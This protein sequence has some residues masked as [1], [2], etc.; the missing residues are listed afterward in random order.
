VSEKYGSPQR[1][2]PQ[3]YQ[4]G[5]PERRLAGETTLSQA[6]TQ[7][8]RVHFNFDTLYE[9]KV[10]ANPLVK[11]RYCFNVGDWFKVNHPTGPK[12]TG[13]GPDD[14]NR[15]QV[16]LDI[17]AENKWCLC[18]AEDLITP[19]WRDFVIEATR[20]H[21]EDIAKYL[22]VKPV[23]GNLMFTK[24]EGSYPAM[25]A[26]TKQQGSYC[27]ADCVKGSHV[28]VPDTLCEV[29]VASDVV[30]SVVGP[31][32]IPGIGGTGGSCSADQNGRPV[33]LVFSWYARSYDFSRDRA[34]LLESTRGLIIHELFHGLGFGSGGWVNVFGADGGRRKI[35]E[36][37][38]VTDADGSEDVVYFFVKGTRTYEAAKRYFGCSDEDQW[39]GL[40][41]MSWPPHGR[42]SHHE[43]RVL[44]DDVMSYGDGDAVSAITLASFEDMG[45]YVADYRNADCIH[46]GQGRGCPFISSRCEE[47]PS[48]Q[49][50][51]GLASSQCD[52]TWTAAK[53]TDQALQ[54]CVA[55]C[56]GS[57][58]IENGKSLCDVEC[59]TGE[60]SELER[61]GFASCQEAPPGEI[62][63]AGPEKW[64]DDLMASAVNLQHCQ[65]DFTGDPCMQALLQL[66]WVV[67]VPLNICFWGLCCKGI[68]CPAGQQEKS[69][70][71]FYILTGFVF[72][73]G[74]LAAAGAG[75]ILAN[76]EVI[77]GYMSVNAV[78][79]MCGAGA[80]L[81]IFCLIGMYAVRRGYRCVMI[82]YLIIGLILLVIFI[83]AAGLSAKY[84]QDVDGLSRSSIA[85]AGE[86]G[87]TWDEKG[88]EKDVYAQM[89][90]FACR[91][92]QTCCEPTE[93]F[94]LREA[95]G[96]GRQCKAQ[97]EGKAE[98]AAFILADPSHPKF[99]PLLSGVT[100]HF[101]S[102]EGVCKLVELASGGGFT[103]AQCQQDYCQS[104]LEGY[105]NFIAVT[106][107][108]YRS[109]MLAAGIIAACVVIFIIVQLWNLYYI[110]RQFHKSPVVPV[111]KD[112]ARHVPQRAED[113]QNKTSKCRFAE[114]FKEA[115]LKLAAVIYCWRLVVAA[116]LRGAKPCWLRPQEFLQGFGWAVQRPQGFT[117]VLLSR[118]F[119]HS[120]VGLLSSVVLIIPTLTGPVVGFL[121]DWTPL[122]KRHLLFAG[123]VT[124][125][126]IFQF[127]AMPALS[128]SHDAAYWWVFACLSLQAACGHGAIFT[129]I[130][131]RMV[132]K[133]AYGKVRLWGGV[134]FAT[135]SFLTGILVKELGYEVIFVESMLVGV[136]SAGCAMMLKGME[137]RAVGKRPDKD[138]SPSLREVLAFLTCPHVAILL[139][140]VIALS[141]GEGVMQTYTYIRLEHLPN[142]TSTIMGLSAIFMIIS[143]VPFFYYANPIFQ[144]F[145]I[146]PILCL[147]LWCMALRQEWIACL[148]D[149]LW[150]LPGELLHG[151]T[152]SIANAAVTLSVHD[153]TPG[154]L[155][156]T[157]QSVVG[158]FC[159][160]FGQSSAS[161]FGGLVVCPHHLEEVPPEVLAL[162]VSR[163]VTQPKVL[164]CTYTGRALRLQLSELII[165]LPFMPKAR[166]FRAYHWSVGAKDRR[167]DCDRIILELCCEWFGSVN[168]FER[169]VRSQIS[170]LIS[171]W[172]TGL[173][174]LIHFA[175]WLAYLLRAPRQTCYGELFANILV[176]VAAAVFYG[177]MQGLYVRLY[178]MVSHLNP[179]TKSS[180]FDGVDFVIYDTMAVANFVHAAILGLAILVVYG[181]G[182][183]VQRLSSLGTAQAKSLERR[184]LV[185]HSVHSSRKR[186]LMADLEVLD[187][188]PKPQPD[189]PE[190]ATNAEP[191]FQ[192]PPQVLALMVSRDVTQPEVLR[193][194]Y[195]GRAL[196]WG[197]QALR[198]KVEAQ[199]AH[200]LSWPCERIAQFWSHSW[201][202]SLWAKVLT[203]LLVQ[204]GTAAVCCG[205]L[206]CIVHGFLWRELAPDLRG[207]DDPL[208]TVFSMACGILVAA[209]TLL[210]WSSGKTVFV[211]QLCIHQKDAQLKL[212]GVLSMGGFLKASESCLVCWDDS[213]S[214]RL[215]CLFELAAFLT[216]REDL[217]L[218]VRPTALGPAVLLLSGAVWGTLLLT[219]LEA[220]VI[221]AY[222]SAAVYAEGMMQVEAL[223]ARSLV[224]CLLGVTAGSYSARSFRAYHW[225]VECMERRLLGFELKEAK[226]SCCSLD[227]KNATGA[228]IPCDRI[229]L[230]LCICEWFGSVNSFERNVRSQVLPSLKGQL[231]PFALPYSWMLGAC[232]PV[233]WGMLPRLILFH[234]DLSLPDVLSNFHRQ[235]SWLISWWLAGLPLLIHFAMWLAYLLRAPRQ[236]C[237]GELFTNMLVCVAAAVFY[238]LMQGLYVLLYV[239][240]SHLNPETK[241]G[242]WDSVEFVIYDT[243]AVA[244]V[245]HAA[246]LGL[247]ILV[248]YGCRCRSAKALIFG[249]RPGEAEKG[250]SEWDSAPVRY[251]SDACASRGSQTSLAA[252][253]RRVQLSLDAAGAAHTAIEPALLKSRADGAAASDPSVL[254]AAEDLAKGAVLFEERSSLCTCGHPGVKLCTVCGQARLCGSCA[255]RM[256]LLAL[257]GP[258]LKITQGQVLRRWEEG[259]LPAESLAAV[260]A[261]PTEAVRS[262]QAVQKVAHFCSA[263]RWSDRRAEEILAAVIRG[264]IE[265]A[266]NASPVGIGYYPKF[267]RLRAANAHA[268]AVLKEAVPAGEP[269]RVG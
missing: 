135:G 247:A 203:L 210:L 171:W 75:A 178:V 28:L 261:V 173:P 86:S 244:N 184:I 137:E 195:A 15:A 158:S 129:E 31:S 16:G 115:V 143:E 96:A 241:T 263:V 89:E 256:C 253:S 200:R 123:L 49:T 103:L 13:A 64:A 63:S 46:W 80:A 53:A 197:G 259:H 167:P 48:L 18:T 101:S 267:A 97:H 180:N 260:A 153:I 91:T 156:T 240:V 225:C 268:E 133:E 152:F 81:A 174:L 150:V 76:Q 25:W 11:D 230:E 85:Q 254:V 209:L 236:T 29:G 82:S 68:L 185:A 51:T 252:T 39:Q 194:T 117:V 7:R 106:V 37:K 59:F 193:C 239:M 95:N 226:C 14:C 50:V 113:P 104:G 140:L 27:D 127:A 234:A 217:K 114:L 237:Y 12:P 92:Y 249:H 3:R 1:Q 164:R 54:K 55:G 26:T 186:E 134:G 136:A 90:S 201:H 41:L 6:N 24:S 175:M 32:P 228:R 132:G 128:W 119:S 111:G 130:V 229:I 172:L 213:Y 204:N 44:R 73:C 57:S 70:K 250:I 188:Y 131:L 60:S 93:L 105:E 124:M 67:L 187:E 78:Y 207:A 154:H 182:V 216:S 176:C 102:A 205:T 23:Q 159:S 125:R 142:G 52:R 79:V 17:M 208:I 220:A 248:V 218:V 199:K 9:D 255:C 222:Q 227:H 40:P 231:G 33:H 179:E 166:S 148:W 62:S 155:E 212:E 42:D 144:R 4:R 202:G 224:V 71:I 169:N 251:C 109:N 145:G 192:V 232:A 65:D 190:S 165:A 21:G 235:F 10:N 163:D 99:C 258:E 221:G 257:I 8:I 211:D 74:I 88:M 45:H 138:R 56:S 149:A 77:E 122:E 206:A 38:K 238:G 215:W 139:F 121:G 5:T 219:E 83:V 2:S 69:K 47:R 34:T 112:K 160:G 242:N 72:L 243:L 181:C 108:I 170:W 20:L 168:S 107:S 126:W 87:G 19:A 177:F 183:E 66:S 98:D 214:E 118:R 189:D 233:M 151:I 265:H 223:A 110:I 141:F 262:A 162:M 196:S 198:G 30:V 269:L 116:R 161:F 43:T 22:R 94:D 35:L 246:I 120:S 146:M 61:L 245:A 36:Q 191:A 157:M 84:A 58:R 147:A 264:R 100:E 266:T